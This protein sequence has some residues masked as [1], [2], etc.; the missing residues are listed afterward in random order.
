MMISFAGAP[1]SIRASHQ[2]S[3]ELNQEVRRSN[4]AGLVL[5]SY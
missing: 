5:I 4:S 1:K 3:E 2:S